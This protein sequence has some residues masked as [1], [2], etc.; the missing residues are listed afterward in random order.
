MNRARRTARVEAGVASVGFGRS[1]EAVEKWSRVSG[2]VID[3]VTGVV[4]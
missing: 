4:S 3:C 1:L 2:T